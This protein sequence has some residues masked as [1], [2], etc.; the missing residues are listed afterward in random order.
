MTSLPIERIAPAVS[1]RAELVV[2][3]YFGA[4]V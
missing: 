1:T 2:N 3:R 4:K